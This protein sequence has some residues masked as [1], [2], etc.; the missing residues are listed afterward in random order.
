MITTR[1][2]LATLALT[3]APLLAQQ[4]QPAA[5]PAPAAPST[6]STGS[7]GTAGTVAAVA[8]SLSPELVGQLTSKLG[9][10]TKQAE[11]GTG[12]ILSY[13]QKALK[14]D[15]YAKVA[16]A[17]PD[18]EKLV[19]AA[20]KED[21]GSAASALSAVGG[22]VGGAASLTSSFSKLGM[23]NETLGKFTPI[24]VDYVKV[25]G[26]DAAGKLLGGILK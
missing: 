23:N 22:K 20:P 9:V 26:G 7:S 5:S 24:V 21:K 16:G 10:T 14:K 11:G 8:S 13:A 17:V 12:A 18:A 19:A 3:A 4:T 15:D 6:S 1:L 2:T 25:K